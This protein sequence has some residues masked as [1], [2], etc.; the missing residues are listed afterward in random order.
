MMRRA[1]AAI[2]LQ[3]DGFCGIVVH[4]KRM[5]SSRIAAANTSPILFI[6]IS[7]AIYQ[8][9]S[10][11]PDERHQ[12]DIERHMFNDSVRSKMV[13]AQAPNFSRAERTSIVGKSTETSIGTNPGA[14]KHRAA[15][16]SHV[17]GSFHPAVHS[18]ANSFSKYSL[19][20]LARL[21]SRVVRF[22]VPHRW[23]KCLRR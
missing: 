22:P 7:R 3:K 16:I 15:S 21:Y 17:P 11:L 20:V 12:S 2:R 23:A 1:E 10:A 6:S 18:T 14:E 13:R 9:N 8:A 5:K 4:R 19:E